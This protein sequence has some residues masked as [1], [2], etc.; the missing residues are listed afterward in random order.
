MKRCNYPGWP[1]IIGIN[2]ALRSGYRVTVKDEV[3]HKR[4]LP[5]IQQRN[6]REWNLVCWFKST[7]SYNK[8]IIKKRKKSVVF[9]KQRNQE[10]K[11]LRLDNTKFWSNNTKQFIWL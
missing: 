7:S 4:F 11:D 2:W 5:V 6:V 8:Q 1:I 9:F 3:Q 10:E